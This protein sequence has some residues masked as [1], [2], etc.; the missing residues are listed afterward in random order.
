MPQ[1]VLFDLDGTLININSIQHLIGQWDEFHEA[2]FSCPAHEALCEL[3]K[4]LENHPQGYQIIVVTGKPEKHRLRAINWLRDNG[5]YA[6][7]ILMRP[8]LNSQSDPD[9]KVALVEKLLG[10][11]WRKAVA[12][13]VE[14]RDKMV[15]RWRAEGIVCLQ[16]MPSLY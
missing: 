16:C 5:V 7:F 3:A 4:M 6:D 8:P 15:N 11:D 1:Y 12:F 10:D 13:A 9:L 2:S 14:D